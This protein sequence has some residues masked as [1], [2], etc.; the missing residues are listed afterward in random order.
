MLPFFAS[1]R[2]KKKL[3][4]SYNSPLLDF[5]KE[6]VGL[7]YL[8]NGKTYLALVT[9]YDLHGYNMRRTLRFSLFFGNLLALVIIGITGYFF[10]RKSDAAV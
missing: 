9:A 3:S 8:K 6:G 2:S 5:K 7:T 10:S 4:F 1:I